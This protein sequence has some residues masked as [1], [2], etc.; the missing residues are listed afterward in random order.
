VDEAEGRIAGV[1]ASR[2]VDGIQHARVDHVAVPLLEV[3]V[4]VVRPVHDDAASGPAARDGERD[5]LLRVDGRTLH[6]ELVAPET[7]ELRH[8]LALIWERAL[9]VADERSEEQRGEP[10]WAGH[11]RMLG[12]DATEHDLEVHHAGSAT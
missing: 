5:R 2:D 4:R 11:Q 7:S 3:V 9:M 12:A 6:D 1:G 10:P 8:E